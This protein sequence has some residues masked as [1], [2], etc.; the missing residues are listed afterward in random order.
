M[1]QS[2]FGLHSDP[3]ALG[4]NLRFLYRSRAHDETM[5]HLSYGLEQGEDLILIVG[6]IGTGK[7]LALQNLQ[8]KVS[9]LFR[10]ILVNV[11]SVDYT[12]FLKL[13]LHEL[14]VAWPGQADRADLL[15]LLKDRA[16]QV[17]AE[18]QKLLLVVDEAQNLDADTLEGIRL[19]ANL[20]QPDKQLFQIV[21]SGQPS[22]ADMIEEPELAQLR[23]RIR[24]HYALEPLS[25]AET[26]EYI[27]HRLAVAGRAEPLFA[28]AA[29][30]RIHE[31][32][33]GIPR[34]VNHLAGNALLAAFVAEARRVE[35]RHV[36][37][38]GMPASPQPV[39]PAPAGGAMPARSDEPPSDAAGVPRAAAV[40]PPAA[41]RA[42]PEPHPTAPGAASAGAD[43]PRSKMPTTRRQPSRSGAPRWGRSWIWAWLTLLGI[44]IL[45][46]LYLLKDDLYGGRA[47]VQPERLVPAPQQHVA[48]AAPG[49]DGQQPTAVDI[50][51]T[52]SSGP[53]VS[54]P[55]PV[56][57]P[58]ADAAPPVQ[59]PPPADAAPPESSLPAAA[60]DGPARATSALAAGHWLHVASFRDNDR[61]VR[62]WAELTVA[63][64]PAEVHEVD[65][66]GGQLWLRIMV[67]PY[68]SRERAAA[69]AADLE[70]RGLVTFHRIMTY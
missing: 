37:A 5:A 45:A 54:D 50:A 58:P 65:L 52:T 12:G 25:A 43:H 53:A 61:A 34:L 13:V 39:A 24:I 2:H 20:G 68:P 48:T 26:N 10:Q 35:E 46:V 30:A 40:T 44:V 9:R 7:T 8:V 64:Y 47:I 60:G 69:A 56:A 4:P 15:C 29:V 3:F 22:L 21:L 19:L 31:L 41:T 63:G 70:R 62:Y 16:R 33:G 1:Y 55:E 51:S 57:S 27:S 38:E 36:A 66:N 14:G 23:Q 28:A 6:A 67:G 59:E 11:T 32:S 42:D 18:G 17:H 49:A